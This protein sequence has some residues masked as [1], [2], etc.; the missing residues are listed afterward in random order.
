MAKDA[1]AVRLGRKGGKARMT[2]MTA[3]ERKRVARN[4][5]NT[6]WAKTKELLEAAERNAKR[7]KAEK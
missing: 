2:K 5:I 1:A 3:E 6:R 4:A 7:K